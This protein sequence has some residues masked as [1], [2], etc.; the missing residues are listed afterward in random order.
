MHEG[1]CAPRPRTCREQFELG[2]THDELW[3][4]CQHEMVH[5]GKMHGFMR[6]YWAKK[7]L[8]WTRTPEEAIEVGGGRWGAAGARTHTRGY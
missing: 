3:N 6:M 8:E 7:I 1:P 5:L 4:A 2:Q